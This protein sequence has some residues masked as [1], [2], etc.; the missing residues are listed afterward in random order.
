MGKEDRRHKRTDDRMVRRNADDIEYV[1]A[2]PSRHSRVTREETSRDESGVQSDN[3]RITVENLIAV[4]RNLDGCVLDKDSVA[5]TIRG[6]YNC[7]IFDPNQTIPIPRLPG[8]SMAD[9]MWPHGAKIDTR[10]RDSTAVDQGDRRVLRDV[11]GDE[12]RNVARS[13]VSSSHGG[14]VG[15]AYKG[16]VIREPPETVPLVSPQS[17]RHAF[18]EETNYP[19]GRHNPFDYR[20][21]GPG[22]IQSPVGTYTHQR[23]NVPR[24]SVLENLREVRRE[25]ETPDP[26]IS[27]PRRRVVV[28]PKA[29]MVSNQQTD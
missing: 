12:L 22:S 2:R 1:D 27:G 24:F 26:P 15:S 11:T 20:E 29:A 18:Q 10:K 7:F 9:L 25:D 16:Y 13:V 17:Q 28:R 8:D 19:V 6:L 21:H 3:L 5:D 4:I 14:D 23:G